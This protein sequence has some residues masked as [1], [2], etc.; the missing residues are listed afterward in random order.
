MLDQVQIFLLFMIW[1]TMV[2][3]DF[4]RVLYVL[5]VLAVGFMVI[6][7][8]IKGDSSLADIWRILWHTLENG[9]KVPNR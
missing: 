5:V 6:A 9:P 2:H 7:L 1:T 4:G 8:L 3:R